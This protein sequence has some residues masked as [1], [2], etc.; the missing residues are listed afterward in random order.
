MIQR[1]DYNFGPSICMVSLLRGLN[2]SQ[3]YAVQDD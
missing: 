3:N 2:L 1:M